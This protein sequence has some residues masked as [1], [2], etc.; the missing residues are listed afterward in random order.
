MSTEHTGKGL[1]DRAMLYLCP[2][3]LLKENWTSLQGREEPLV[4]PVTV[5]RDSAPTPYIVA[6]PLGFAFQGWSF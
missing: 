5:M 1:H 3:S 2:P 4:L 6:V